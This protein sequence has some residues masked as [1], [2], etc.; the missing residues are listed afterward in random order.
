MQG[1]VG[2]FARVVRRNMTPSLGMML[3]R[4]IDL[5]VGSRE[6]R[7]ESYE[8]RLRCVVTDGMTTNRTLAILTVQTVQHCMTH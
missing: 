2:H 8:D 7:E 4:G 6:G 5:R 3:K 1:S